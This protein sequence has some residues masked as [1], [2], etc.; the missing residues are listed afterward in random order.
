M[1]K[2]V[3]NLA[4]E[5][6]DLSV[7]VGTGTGPVKILLKEV[8]KLLGIVVCVKIRKEEPVL[9]VVIVIEDLM[10]EELSLSEADSPHLD[11]VWVARASCDIE[12][13][14]ARFV[15]GL[16]VRDGSG[17]AVASFVFEGYEREAIVF[18]VEAVSN[19][20]S[21]EC[22]ENGQE[23]F[24]LRVSIHSS[25]SVYLYS[26]FARAGAP[27]AQ[28]IAHQTSDLGVAGSSPVGCISF[29]LRERSQSILQRCSDST[30]SARAGMRRTCC[31][32]T[33]ADR[34]E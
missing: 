22:C 9:E 16:D 21:E 33:C 7:L 13:H 24:C 20:S 27:V 4:P 5:A 17:D 32:C 28:W 29:T 6:V 31:I 18:V 19:L 25:E 12:A 1:V 3:S 10:L 2:R 30:D 15:E 34:V 23:H 11:E 8:V 14:P 26:G